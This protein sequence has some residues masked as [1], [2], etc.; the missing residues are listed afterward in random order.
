MGRRI[1]VTG[2][3]TFWGARMAQ[4]LEKDPEVDLIL[5][6]G[7]VDP[8]VELT[9]TEFIK[10]DQSYSILARIVRATRV[11]TVVHTFLVTD[12]TKVS[13]RALNEINVIGT[14]N[15]LAAAGGP[16]SSVRQV[17]MKSSTLVYGTNPRD[18]S[19][20]TESSKRSSPATSRLERTL[21]DA[22]SYVRDFAEDNPH[23]TVSL[24]RFANVLGT[25]IQTPTTMNLRKSRLPYIVGFDPQ[26]QFVEEDDV[27]RAL[28]FVTTNQIPGVFNV[29]GDSKIPW[30]EVAKISGARRI[31]ISAIG[32]DMA[33]MPLIK[34]GLIEAPPELL[35]LLRYGRGVD[36]SRLKSSGFTY[37]YTSAGAVENF[38][39][40]HQLRRSL[41]SGSSVYKYQHDVEAFFRHSPAVIRQDAKSE[42]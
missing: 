41:G 14:M 36:N 18:P 25:D 9:R 37:R 1:L 27:V 42:I 7:S 20:F 38:T 13:G 40:S 29:A 17:V 32:T 11:E 5:G 16:S 26:I 30:S 23:V 22:E 10:T 2:V 19:F 3:D 34:F 6:V 12:S 39:L 35:D 24:L 8:P 21:V 15:L 4:A 33:V 31:P 28:E